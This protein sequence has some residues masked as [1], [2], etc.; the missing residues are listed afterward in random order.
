MYNKFLQIR[1]DFAPIIYSYKYDFFLMIAIPYLQEWLKI[2][3]AKYIHLCS[4][5]NYPASVYEKSNHDNMERNFIKN[6][7]VY[8]I[9]IRI[10]KTNI[11]YNIC[12]HISK[13]L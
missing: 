8:K 7:F 1:S 9:Q 10:N 11:E 2:W 12:S 4:L 5:I 13:N 6:L 3:I